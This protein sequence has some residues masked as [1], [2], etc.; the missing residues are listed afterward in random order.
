M[1]DADSV[2]FAND[3][4][5]DLPVGGLNGLLSE[6]CVV[7]RC[8]VGQDAQAQIRRVLI[9]DAKRWDKNHDHSSMFRINSSI[10]AYLAERIRYE[11]QF[12]GMN[13]C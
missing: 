2:A 13:H 12:V 8:V 10:I 3:R 5:C 6:N 7:Q 9:D 11:A 4:E 1:R